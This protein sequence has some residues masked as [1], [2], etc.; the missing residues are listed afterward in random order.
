VDLGLVLPGELCL[1]LLLV[2]VLAVIHDPGDRW[3]GL[4]RDLD[5]VEIL[6]VRVLTGL[7]GRCDPDLLSVLVDEPHSRYADPVVDPPLR[8]RPDW[9]DEP[10]RPQRLLTKLSLPPCPTTKAAAC[11]GPFPVGLAT[12][13]NLRELTLGR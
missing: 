9:F 4:G 12:R 10:S 1:L 5:E 2:P 3:V 13:L 7:V 11:S 6:R 8:N